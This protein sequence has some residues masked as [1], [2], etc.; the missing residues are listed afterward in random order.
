MAYSWL[1]YWLI[2]CYNSTMDIAIH[3]ESAHN[4]TGA[5]EI[6]RD[7]E[8]LVPR[9]T[10]YIYIFLDALTDYDT[11]EYRKCPETVA[12]CFPN[13]F[14]EDQNA[15]IT[16]IQEVIEGGS[17]PAQIKKLLLNL[18]R[19]LIQKPV[20][21]SAMQPVF[22]HFEIGE[23]HTVILPNNGKIPVRFRIPNLLCADN[24]LEAFLRACG[25]QDDTKGGKGSHTKWLNGEGKTIFIRSI[26]SKMWLKMVIKE[27]LDSGLSINTIREACEKLKIKFQTI[28]PL[29]YA[30]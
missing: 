15:I 24:Q 13:G 26:S 10:E 27:L 25:L 21:L 7:L 1:Q 2:L 6:L 16:L 14:T 18:R 12:N 5:P 19:S 30:A 22:D 20:H 29:N 11:P 17:D 3:T 23:Q 28:D 4:N 9:A 8:K